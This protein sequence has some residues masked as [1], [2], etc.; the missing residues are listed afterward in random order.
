M[1][2]IYCVANE[3]RIARVAAQRRLRRELPERL[4]ERIGG[5]AEG[6]QRGENP[7][8]RFERM[9]C[10]D[11]IHV[12]RIAAA[13]V[14]DVAVTPALR[15]PPARI[16]RRKRDEVRRDGVHGIRLR[17][18]RDERKLAQQSVEPRFA[19]VRPVHKKRPLSRRRN[20]WIGEP[21]CRKN[22]ELVFRVDHVV[23]LAHAT[24]ITQHHPRPR[25]QAVDD[26]DI[27]RPRRLLDERRVLTCCFAHGLAAERLFMADLSSGGKLAE[28]T[29]NHELGHLVAPNRA[30][31]QR[32]HQHVAPEVR[33]IGRQAGHELFV[34]RQQFEPAHL[35]LHPP[36]TGSFTAS[37]GEEVQKGRGE[38][39]LAGEW[40]ERASAG[41]DANHERNGRS[42]TSAQGHRVALDDN[43]N[44]TW[45]G[46]KLQDERIARVDRRLGHTRDCG[47]LRLRERD[48]WPQS[49]P[50][51]LLARGIQEG[52]MLRSLGA[53]Q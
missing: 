42:C 30:H 5:D 31:H 10:P 53:G 48:G 50:Q 51:C 12:H 4:A 45:I 36:R 41:G 40:R 15:R 22:R 1:P 7:V 16:A 49:V 14:S 46:A 33:R 8:D 21:P 43:R 44:A 17:H 18:P 24:H 35:A 2:C 27:A 26:P 23:V 39:V 13:G 29:R 6:A 25:Q 11:P 28:H 34:R 32:R 37:G 3:I 9:R 52:E 19:A 47:T 38:D 20:G